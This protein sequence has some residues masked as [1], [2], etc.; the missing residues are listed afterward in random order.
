MATKKLFGGKETFKEELNEAK[1][2][3]SGK[4]SPIQYAKGEESEKEKKMAKGG[5]AKGAMPKSMA[6]DVEAGSNKL[7]KFGQ[8]KVQKRGLTKGK[9][10]GDTGAYKGEQTGGMNCGG[11][12]KKM[13]AGGS[14]SSRAD[15]IAQKG[16]TKGKWC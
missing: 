6:G 2:I 1:A 7:G 11:K 12:V 16:K 5:L 4:I 3:K 10:F 14:V 8:S 15:G 9:N 13:A